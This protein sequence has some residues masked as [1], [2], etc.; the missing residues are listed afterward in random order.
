MSAATATYGMLA[1]DFKSELRTRYALNALFMFVVTAV[2][3]ILF[4]LRGESPG[5]DV[6]A[7]MFW[8]VIFFSSMSGLA[9]T[10]VSE[11]ER[12][13]A[14]TLQLMTSPSV[15]YF[16]K[17]LF[18]VVLSLSLTVAITVLYIIAFPSFVVRSFD[19]FAITILLG[20]IGLASATTIIAAIIARAGTKGT[21][22]PVLSFPVLLPLLMTVM[23]STA[24]ALEGEALGRA[25]GQFQIL[26][27]YI[28][29]MVAGSYLL[30]DYVWKD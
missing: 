9:R 13:T 20:S 25:L 8:T 17:L 10:F 29:V 11:E 1:K 16:G 6:L 4:A 30:F 21:L 28:L 19:I 15:V 12:G 3:I 5:P 7:G 23:N 18:N 24:M 2:S 27:S 26:V 22:Y 14:F